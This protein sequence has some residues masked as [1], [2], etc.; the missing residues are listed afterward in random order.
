MAVEYPPGL[1]VLGYYG[2]DT[3]H[4]LRTV[5][6]MKP[7]KVRNERNFIDE[8]LRTLKSVPRARLQV[9]RDVVGALAEPIVREKSQPKSRRTV[10]KSLLATA[11]CGMWQ[12]R[13]DVGNSRAY[14]MTLR[15]RLEN[16]GDR[17]KNFR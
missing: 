13:T 11:F 6:I 2:S 16:R 14:A 17:A 15:Q 12:S 7:A 9:V 8:I 5:D 4:K 10:R 3:V 1:T